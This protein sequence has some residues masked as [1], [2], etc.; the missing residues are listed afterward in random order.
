MPRSSFVEQVVF[1]FSEDTEYFLKNIRLKQFSTL[2]NFERTK[3]KMGT[4]E[5]P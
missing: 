3:S 5:R 4:P 1:L 2:L